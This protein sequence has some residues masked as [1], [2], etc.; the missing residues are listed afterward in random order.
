MS[1]KKCTLEHQQLLNQNQN[2]NNNNSGANTSGNSSSTS[3]NLLF[4][5]IMDPFALYRSFLPTTS[6]SA[7]AATAAATAATLPYA[8]APN[9][10]ANLLQQL[11]MLVNPQQQDLISSAGLNISN[12]NNNNGFT[13][14]SLFKA[15]K[16]SPSDEDDTTPPAIDFLEI[17]KSLKKNAIE[18]EEPPSTEENEDS[19]EIDQKPYTSSILHDNIKQQLEDDSFSPELKPLRSRSFLTDSQV[20][21]LTT[22]FKRNPFPSK[23][24]LSALAEQIGVNKRV[25]QVWFQNMRAKER[26]SNRLSAISDRL[27]RNAWKN[28]NNNNNNNNNIPNNNEIFTSNMIETSTVASLC[29]PTA[30]TTTTTMTTGVNDS[31][32]QLINAWSQ[33]IKV[34]D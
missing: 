10:Y 12:N 34:R 14:D 33:A 1:S 6:P 3:P 2:N 27:S 20:A 11:Q 23:Y 28:N 7:A 5:P 9:V 25:V 30:T 32:L 17:F 26:R 18:K 4:P 19:I 21:I 24:D 15:K 22:H 16:S 8:L 31:T 13:F 29:S